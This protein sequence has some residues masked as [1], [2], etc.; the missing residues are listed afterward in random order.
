M[1]PKF[2]HAFHDGKELFNRVACLLH[3][4]PPSVPLDVL[5]SVADAPELV[6]ATAVDDVLILA[7]EQAD[8]ALELRQARRCVACDDERIVGS[9]L[10]RAQQVEVR[11]SIRVQI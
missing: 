6:V 7:D 1:R 10:Q 5:S 8:G 9:R 3:S 2:S 11:G 4:L